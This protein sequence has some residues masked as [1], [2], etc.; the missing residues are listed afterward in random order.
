[1]T[2]TE[3]ERGDAATTTTNVAR[4]TGGSM[5]REAPQGPAQ[6]RRPEGVRPLPRATVERQESW[7]REVDFLRFREIADGVMGRCNEVRAGVG[8]EPLER[9]PHCRWT[10]EQLMAERHSITLC[11]AAMAESRSR[12]TRRERAR[13]H[14]ELRL[15][16]S[17][18]WKRDHDE[19]CDDCKGWGAHHFGLDDAGMQ[20]VRFASPLVARALGPV[21]RPA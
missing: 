20:Q 17:E 9:P 7:Q 12:R 15:E 13:L 1:M 14:H 2:E 21:G 18:E 3:D 4:M 6:R 5:R 10:R 16:R 8:L 11:E 19:T